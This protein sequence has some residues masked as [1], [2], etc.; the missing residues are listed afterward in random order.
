MVYSRCL[1]TA[2]NKGE[3]LE[4]YPL[5]ARAPSPGS[6]QLSW[7][8]SQPMASL[9]EGKKKTETHVRH[10]DFSVGYKRDW[11]QSS[12]SHSDDRT[13]YTPNAKGP[14]GEKK[15]K[16]K[17]I[18]WCAAVAPEDMQYHRQTPE[19]ARDYKLLKKETRNSL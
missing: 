8:N 7:E 6:A 12:M 18:G 5:T 11:S 16:E 9:W 17:A 10:S 13:Q 19:G 2:E 14:L 15:Q 3:C 1:R 4:S